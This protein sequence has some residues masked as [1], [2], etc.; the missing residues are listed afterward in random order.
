MP[1]NLFHITVGIVFLLAGMRTAP[2]VAA[3]A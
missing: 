2:A 3:R 1:D